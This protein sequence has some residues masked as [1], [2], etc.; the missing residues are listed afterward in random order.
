MADIV[1]S[2]FGLTPGMYQ[3]A[4]QQRGDEMALQYAKLDPFQQANYAIGRGAYGLAGAAGGLLGGQDPELQRITRRQQIASQVDFTNPKSIQEGINLLGDDIMGKQQLA[5]I[6]RQQ[7]ESGALIGQ[8]EAA[9]LASRA[10]A[11]TSA[12]KASDIAAQQ[13]AFA[14]LM[15]GQVPTAPATPAAAAPTPAMIDQATGAMTYAIPSQTEISGTALPPVTEQARPTVATQPNINQQISELEKRRS[16]FLSLPE[17]PDAKAQAEVLGDQIKALREQTKPTDL[18]RLEDE[19]A[20]L[21]QAGV[22]ENDPKIQNRLSKM[23]KLAGAAERFGPDAERVAK[24]EFGKPYRSLS[25]SEAATVDKIVESRK[26]KVAAAGATKVVMPPQEKEELGARGKLL[27]EQYKDISN[28]AKV[29]TRILPAIDANL[30]ILG[31]GF[32]TGFGT[33][34]KAAGAKVLAALGVSEAEKFAT[35]A[36]VFQSKATEAV[37]QKQLEQKGPQTE[38]DAQRI[39]QIGSQLG[40]TTEGN[41][42]LLTTAKEQLKRDMEQR[43]FYDSWW[44]QNKTYDGAED[45]W[46]S[47][48]GGK[49][50]FDRP[51]LKKYLIPTATSA[52]IPTAAVPSSATPAPVYARNPKTN[53]RIMSTDGGKTWSPVRQ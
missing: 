45:A 23:E 26:Q 48:E 41:K 14:A 15:G 9:A 2:L 11:T 49:S 13:K 18:S 10:A 1:P 43:N 16:Q 35:N 22:P 24:V 29:A 20:G 25:Q 21:R 53:Q 19:I 7:L 12:A 28:Q 27:V 40:K 47:G 33:E 44:K 51:A 50:L 30:D 8:R 4:Q 34:T 39:D 52:S 37:L 36:Q 42:F 17:V 38:S 46:Y 31:K 5:A 3:Q 6:Y 32:E